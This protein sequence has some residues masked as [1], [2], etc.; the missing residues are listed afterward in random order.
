MKG[1][2]MDIP[3][4]F[5]RFLVRE[6]KISEEDLLE[7]TRVQSEINRSFAV[8]ALEGD[9]ITLDDFKKAVAYQREK[10][11]KFRDAIKELKIA[12]ETTLEK[13]DKL[14]QDK[15]IKLGELLVK[16]GLIT[17]SDLNELLKNF[18]EKGTMELV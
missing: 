6:G 15:S 5:G 13:I 2:F 11:V 12:D 18:Q 1:E 16:R 17:K 7:V 14:L 4:L 9:F 3:V 8:T 10:G